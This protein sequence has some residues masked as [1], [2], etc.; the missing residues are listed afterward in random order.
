MYLMVAT[1]LASSLG[2]Y[3]KGLQLRRVDLD[4]ESVT[5]N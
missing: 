3:G 4:T 1:M 2:G 5:C